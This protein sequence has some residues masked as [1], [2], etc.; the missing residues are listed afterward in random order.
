M[1][2]FGDRGP[3]LS[4]PPAP[5][6]PPRPL[7]AEERATLLALLNHADFPGRDALIEQVDAA[8]VVSHCSCG[9]ATI[10]LI[11]DPAAPSAGQ[12]YRPVPNEAEVVDDEDK[13]IGGVIVFTEDGYLSSLE[14]YSYGGDPISAFPSHDR[15]RLRIGFG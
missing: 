11:V 3:L 12:T 14:I 7:L 8:R 2:R 1:A 13:G 9:C 4:V 5:V 15:L 6:E 10:D